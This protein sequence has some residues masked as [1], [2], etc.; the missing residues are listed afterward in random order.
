[1]QMEVGEEQNLQAP[2]FSQHTVQKKK[3]I[4]VLVFIQGVKTTALI[5]CGATKKFINFS[6]KKK[7]GLIP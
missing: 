3:S 6:F 2:S 4:H 7:K 5:D 1:M